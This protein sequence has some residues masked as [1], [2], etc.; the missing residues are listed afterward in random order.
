MCGIVG[1][2][3]QKK[4]IDIIYNGL[5][6]LE[7]RGYDSAGIAA[8]DGGEVGTVKAEGKLA[9]LKALLPQLP[10]NA[11]R[12][13][14]HTRWATHG[15]PNTVNAHPHTHDNVALV[16]NGII[17]NYEELKKDLLASG[18]RFKSET[19]TEVVLQ[20]FLRE[21]KRAGTPM[22]AIHAMLPQLR[23]AFSL[24]ILV[25]SEPEALYVVKQGS[26]LVIGA[27]RGENFFASDAMA[28]V[29]HTSRAHFLNDGEVARITEKD[30]KIWSF[31]GQAIEPRFMELDISSASVEKQGFKHFML[32]EIHEQ[33]RVL[34][35]ML[36]RLVNV[37]AK[38][39]NGA[40]LG[41]DGLDVG[42]ITNV[43]MVACGTAYYSA[44][45][46]K[47]V[48]EPAVGLPV[49][50]ELASEFRYREPWLSKGTLV[51]AVS[52][53]GETADTLA[54]VKHAKAHG[55]QVMAVCNVK[56]SSIPRECQ[57]TLHMDAGPEIGVAST[58]AFTSMILS[59]YLFGLAFGLK[60]GHL[61]AADVAPVFG[62]LRSLP[63]LMDH[64]IDAKAAVEAV[65]GKYY[66][67]TNFIFIG[68]GLSFAIALEG[69]LKLKEISYIHAEGYA[70]GEL[71]HGPIALIDRHMP[72]VAVAPRDAYYEKMLS[73][74]EEVR[75][76]EGRVIAVGAEG[77]Q[78]L[79][80][81]GDDYLG[82]PESTDQAVQA[83]LSVVP[84][85]LLAYYVA[86][87]RGTD[88]DQPRNLAKS[89]TV[90]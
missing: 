6:R 62:K 75:A 26:P 27:G 34:S 17:E 46:G 42:R 70:G 7:Y 47:Y 84:L 64:A 63:A 4:C 67:A 44:Q 5:A 31:D 88:V 16:H 41:V 82:G 54:C 8:L 38:T 80:R 73:N 57:V 2:I 58:K 77:D 23:G 40:E 9:G 24:G 83:I 78:K 45:V 29:A 12:G 49:S 28:L 25:G 52:Q 22:K 18:A 66:E 36:K 90:E 74:I 76:R 43:V 15:V 11:T 86:V 48:I 37:D 81:L 50:V 21:L 32:K 79:A 59:H 72:I 71:K 87:K 85:Q 3:G 30:V 1:Y 13:I 35:G 10:Q 53:S 60:R 61:K 56:M 39:L 51:I 55:C 14:G 65:A 19:D 69:A 20:L 68:R 89:V 33:P